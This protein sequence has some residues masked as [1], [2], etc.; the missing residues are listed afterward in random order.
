MK[1]LASIIGLKGK[2]GK[3]LTKNALDFD[4]EILGGTGKKNI[5][6]LKN[7]LKKSQV[8]IDFSS[9]RA[10]DYLLYYAKKN[11]TPLIIGTT[12]YNLNDLKKIKKASRYFPICYSANFSL[13]IALLRTFSIQLSKIFNK[14]F[15]DIIE[16]HHILKKDKPSGT[17][18]TLLKDL[19]NNLEKKIN[20]H[21]I[22]AGNIIGQH[23]ILFTAKN[24]TI[25]IKHVANC[26]S[27]FAKGALKAA[28]I[29]IN[30]KPGLYSIMDLLG[31]LY[32]TN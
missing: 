9:P 25:E 12:G 11:L 22:R 18:L 1:I 26:R 30:K 15:V 17:A 10:L 27:I 32:E 7:L 13:G 23:S 21:S 8:A 19:K 28:R 14:S 6:N 24:E 4:I 16:K 3:E 5:K 31:D 2:M 20:I 29:I